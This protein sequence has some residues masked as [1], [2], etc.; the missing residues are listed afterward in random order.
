MSFPSIDVARFDD[1]M[2][3]WPWGQFDLDL[4][5]GSC[6]R[7]E[8]MSDEGVHAPRRTVPVAVM[9]GESF[10][11]EDEGP[12]PVLAAFVSTEVRSTIIQTHLGLGSLG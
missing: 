6:K 10:A 12:K 1:W 8:V 11:L 7:S 3:V 5:V 9:K 2:F 4:R